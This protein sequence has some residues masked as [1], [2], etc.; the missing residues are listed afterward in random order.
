MNLYIK[1]LLLYTILFSVLDALT[2]KYYKQAWPTLS[3]SE[4]IQLVALLFLH[5]A[6]YFVLWIS[7]LYFHKYYKTTPPNYLLFYFL[8][9]IFL[10]ISWVTNGGKCLVTEKQNELLGIPL[11]TGFRDFY[12]ILTDTYPENAGSNITRD[13]IYSTVLY[14]IIVYSLYLYL[15]RTK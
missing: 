12:A 8:G 1:G 2:N 10:K 9:M 11:D 4:K 6:L 7:I 13:K 5:N 14:F 3:T 15:K